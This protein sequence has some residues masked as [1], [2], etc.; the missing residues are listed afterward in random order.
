ME[1]LAQGHSDFQM[2]AEYCGIGYDSLILSILNSAR[3][4]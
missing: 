3:Q 2:I 1:E 4:T